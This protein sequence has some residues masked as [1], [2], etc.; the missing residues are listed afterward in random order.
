MNCCCTCVGTSTTER[1]AACRSTAVLVMAKAMPFKASGPNLLSFFVARKIRLLCVKADGGLAGQ[2]GCWRS[3]ILW[4]RFFPV[5]SVLLSEQPSTELSSTQQTEIH[6][7][8]LFEEL[9]AHLQGQVA[10]HLLRNILESTGLWQVGAT[11][12]PKQTLIHSI[13]VSTSPCMQGMLQRPSMLC[14]LGDGR[15][16]GQNRFQALRCD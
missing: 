16:Q 2:P 12:L 14:K 9:P 1:S 5:S 13:Y 3:C 11:A 15:F 6:E 10:S 4:T 8:K 7:A